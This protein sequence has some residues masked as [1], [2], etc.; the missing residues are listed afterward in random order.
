MINAQPSRHRDNLDVCIV[1][2]GPIGIELAVALKQQ[3]ISCQII[4]AG[5]I[6][7]T[8]SWWAPETRWFSS[9]ERIA[10]AG[11]PLVTPD[12][13]KATREQYL[14]YL[15]SVVMQFDVQ[16][17]SF[18]TVVAIERQAANAFV[19]SSQP[20]NGDVIHQTQCQ[21]VVLAIGGT[22]F[23]RRL[24]IPG[25]TLPHVDGYLREPHR[26]FG[27]KVL[28]VGGRNSAAEAALRLHHAGADVA[29]SYRGD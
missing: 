28:V 8:M 26:Y 4:E 2:A 1:G 22:D 21:H 17:R 24:A 9:N 12:Q 18:E 14:A 10:I 11:V 20:Q 25:E 15:R 23:P 3:G 13:S 29:I 5:P 7:Q 19:V 6:G 16:V 27:R